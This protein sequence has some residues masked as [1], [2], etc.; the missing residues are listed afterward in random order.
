MKN[1]FKEPLINHCPTCPALVQDFK[2]TNESMNPPLFE[3]SMSDRLPPNT[4]VDSTMS[5]GFPHPHPQPQE[6]CCDSDVCRCIG[7]FFE[8]TCVIIGCCLCAL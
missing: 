3:S 2:G 5:G 6:D 7:N 8:Y 1:S 4:H